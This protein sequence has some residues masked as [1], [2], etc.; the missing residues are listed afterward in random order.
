MS[1]KITYFLQEGISENT[2]NGETV[3]ESVDEPSENGASS[4]PDE[5]GEVNKASDKGKSFGN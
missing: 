1:I 3:A 4:T 5:N 2:T